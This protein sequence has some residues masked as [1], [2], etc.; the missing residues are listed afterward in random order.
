MAVLAY[1]G[2]GMDARNAMKRFGCVNGDVLGAANEFARPYH[3]ARRH[4][5]RMVPG[6]AALVTAGGKGSR[7]S[8]L[9]VEKPLVPVLGRS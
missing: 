8:E 6:I 7:I 4:R 5:G 3:S 1:P 2:R 9:G